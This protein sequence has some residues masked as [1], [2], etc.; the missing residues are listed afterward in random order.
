MVRSAAWISSA[1]EEETLGPTSVG[2]RGGG[3]LDLGIYSS[4]VI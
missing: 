3:M 4:E 2:L 1:T